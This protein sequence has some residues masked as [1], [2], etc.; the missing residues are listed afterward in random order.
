MPYMHM[1]TVAG[2]HV[3]ANK[4]KK[5]IALT[6]ILTQAYKASDANELTLS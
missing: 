1:Y 6:M 2:R 3:K 5:D 4:D